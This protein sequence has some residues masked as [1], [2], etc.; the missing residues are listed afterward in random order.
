MKQYVKTNKILLILLAGCVLVSL[1]VV[2]RRWQ[3]E[4]DNKTYDIVLDYSELE[5]LAEQSEHDISWWQIGRA[6]C[7]ERV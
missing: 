7:R 2:A 5:L 4:S 3:L 6:S 1:A